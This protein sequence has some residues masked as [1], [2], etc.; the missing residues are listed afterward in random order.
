MTF[1]HS[2]RM[3]SGSKSGYMTIHPGNLVVFNANIC[4]KG[5]IKIWYGDLDIT[6]DTEM[7]LAYRKE[8]GEDLYILY[9]MDARFD[10]EAKP[11]LERAV[12]IVSE[13]EV[14]VQHQ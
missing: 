13:T 7:L 10:S 2:G 9:E 5:G 6:L 3:I 4:T 12:A 11:K 8:V 1:F 14:K